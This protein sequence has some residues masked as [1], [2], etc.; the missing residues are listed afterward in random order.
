MGLLITERE[1]RDVVV[2]WKRVE[3][4]ERL[5][6]N[7]GFQLEDVAD[8]DVSMQV[9]VLYGIKPAWNC[10]SEHGRIKCVPTEERVSEPDD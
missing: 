2:V 9:P 8:A 4:G 6:V 1:A 10:M 3:N 7:L 5:P